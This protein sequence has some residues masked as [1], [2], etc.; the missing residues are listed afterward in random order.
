[1]LPSFKV[2]NLSV[3]TDFY[4]YLEIWRSGEF[5]RPHDHPGY[6]K[7][8]QVGKQEPYAIVY[9]ENDDP[10]IIYP[11][12]FVK[13]D[14][15]ISLDSVSSYSLM[16]SAYGYGGPIQL[17]SGEVDSHQFESMLDEYISV[18][19]VIS[20]FVREDLFDDYK[21]PRRFT[22]EMQQENVVVDLTRSPEMLWKEYKHSVRKNVNRAV[23]SGLEIVF[24][25][26]GSKLD[27]FVNVYHMT[28]RR[29][30]AKESFLISKEMFKIF[31]KYLEDRIGFYVHA[32]LDG[33]VIATELVLASSEYL[34]S[35]LGGANIEFSNLRPSDYLKHQVN[36]WAIENGYRGYVLGGGFKPYD[37]IFNF[38][39]AFD[40][41]GSRPFRIQKNIHNQ[42]AY[43]EAIDSRKRYELSTGIDWEP[44]KSFFPAFMQGNSF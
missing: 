18:N 23:S 26:N 25:F 38:K 36:I 33:K 3:S 8:M 30:G 11:F 5:K 42:L 40:L 34:Y 39:L 41:N 4:S 22:G 12:Y 43:K 16:I 21:V 9:S 27:D 1:M 6:M 14:G 2:Y 13:L 10:K 28:M 44:D 37:G 20:E 17:R 31:N 32:I 7:L 19:N 29:T 15:I 24:D 35:F